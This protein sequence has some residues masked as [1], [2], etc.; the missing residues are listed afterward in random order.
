MKFKTST[1]ALSATL[2]AGLVSSA[3]ADTTPTTTPTPT[4]YANLAFKTNQ[5]YTVTVNGTTQT[6]SNGA[7]SGSQVVVEKSAIEIDSDSTEP[8]T[9]TPT[10]INS[11]ENSV[12]DATEL[13]FNVE[14]SFV[15][16][17]VELAK[18]PGARCGF[19]IK[20]D[21][22]TPEYWLF[23]G[24]AWVQPNPT[25]T[26]NVGPG[27]MF[28]LKVRLDLRS[29][30]KTATYFVEGAKIG[31][32]TLAATAPVAAIDFVGNGS[33][34]ALR[35]DRLAIVSEKIEINPGSG[36]VTLVI[37]ETAIAAIKTKAGDTPVAEYLNQEVNVAESGKP[38]VKISRLDAQVLFGKPDPVAADATAVKVKGTPAVASSAE[39]V[40]VNVV[41]L[42]D[43]KVG[44]ATITYQLEGSSD[45]V[46]FAPDNEKCPAV[47]NVEDL[48][49][50]KNTNWRF[51][52][53]KTSVSYGNA[54]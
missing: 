27:T 24:T 43:V 17:T 7:W 45:G 18:V 4:P 46:N 49:F 6:P 25:A 1:L 9:F 47:T 41:G 19:A 10:Q 54:Q 11:G 42:T 5:T 48:E 30:V 15:P 52:R 31:E 53:V 50:P 29:D 3:F 21:G 8:L 44:G 51:I 12:C 22:E 40:R 33:L 14:A 28:N 2:A 34:G 35:G 36:N 39:K 38:A 26:V 32:T 23:N 13:D 16:A 20:L 37:P